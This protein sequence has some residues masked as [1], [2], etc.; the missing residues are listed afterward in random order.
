MKIKHLVSL[1]SLG[2]VILSAACGDDDDDSAASSAFVN[3]FCDLHE[4]LCCTKRGKTY[5]ASSCKNLLAF[6]GAVGTFNKAEGEACIAG[7]KAA[8][9]SATFCSDYGGAE[10]QKHCNAAYTQKSGSVQ[11]GGACKSDTECAAVPNADVDCTFSS[12]D[13]E[14]STRACQ[15]VLRGKAGDDCAGSKTTTASGV[16]ATSKTGDFAPTISVCWSEDDLYC[17]DGKCKAPG[18]MGDPCKPSDQYS[19]PKDGF[20]GVEDVSSDFKCMP[21]PKLGEPCKNQK[22]ATGSH[23][24]FTSKTCEADVPIGGACTTATDCGEGADCDNG[25]C[26]AAAVSFSLFCK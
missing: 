12:A 21:A 20:C 23:C 11:P 2:F 16:S 19:C 10:V 25:K 1:A 5:D 24:G 26:A 4:G 9:S 15:A 7:M 6:A 17:V 18:K 8:Q 22:C 3:D 14:S 13:F